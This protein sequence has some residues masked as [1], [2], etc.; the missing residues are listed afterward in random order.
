MC[1]GI[2]VFAAESPKLVIGEPQESGGFFLMIAR[3]TEA[4]SQKRDLEGLHGGEERLVAAGI[5]RR[6]LRL[7]RL[8]LFSRCHQAGT[9]GGQKRVEDNVGDQRCISTVDG[10]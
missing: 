9:K 4:L 2:A 5:D 10:E 6:Y 1:E 8:R 7:Q 3:V